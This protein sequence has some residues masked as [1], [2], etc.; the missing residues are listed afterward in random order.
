MAKSELSDLRRFLGGSKADDAETSAPRKLRY[1]VL[2]RWAVD[3]WQQHFG[4]TPCMALWATENCSNHRALKR[5]GE[6][7][8]LRAK[9]RYLG[10]QRVE[11]P[12]VVPIS[13]Y[14][15]PNRRPVLD[16]SVGAFRFRFEQN[17]EPF[18][19]IY[20]SSYYE[21]DD[22]GIVAVVVLPTDRL[23]AWAAFETACSN[24]ARHLE[25]SQNVYIIGGAHESFKPTVDWKDVILPESLKNDLRADMEAFFS[26][27]VNIYKQLGLAPFRKLL[28]VGPPGTGKT[29]LCAAVAKLA[30]AQRRVVVYVS[31]ADDDGASFRKV[32][33]ALNVVA[34]AQHPVLLIVEEID[35][36]LRKDDKAQILNVLDGLESPN[37][38]R[39]AML[40][41]T[42][43]YPEVIDERIAKRPGR[44]DR[45]IHVPLIQDMV[46]AE[47]MLIRY[48][49]HQW[50]EEHRAILPQLV[51]QT[52]AFVRE[53]ALYARM[54]AAHNRQTVV[55]LEVLRQSV[56]SLS[57]QL[58]TG[59]DLQPRR[60][61]G[62]GGRR[63]AFES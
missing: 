50:Q 43:N 42:T 24:A 5:L 7:R 62:F 31:G 3:Y 6:G 4:E 29:T 16:E 54:L 14:R 22:K 27:G 45:I 57:S 9:T 49:G 33:H 17:G 12:H 59:A 48:M 58:A 55:S 1:E 15:L 40:L 30:L 25:R 39:G 34:E 2:V 13:D 28:L 60:S 19:A 38:P 32:H 51:G 35:V 52:G 37:N 21:D 56:N 8:K 53:V 23:E 41:A 10:Y 36:Y 44:V 47:Q 20:V 63:N 11:C 61:I 46:Q 26:E 18:E